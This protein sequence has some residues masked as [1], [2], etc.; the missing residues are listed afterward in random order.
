MNMGYDVDAVEAALVKAG[1]FDDG[2]RVQDCEIRAVA[3]P[4]SV[5][6]DA[7]FIEMAKIEMAKMFE[8]IRRIPA[9]FPY[10]VYYR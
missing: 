5:E 9:P 6:S 3:V 1:I 7:E 8:K 4:L 2:N 10:G